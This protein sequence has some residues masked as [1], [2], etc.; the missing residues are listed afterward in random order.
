MVEPERD[1]RHILASELSTALSSPIDAIAPGSL[2]ETDFRGKLPV[3]LAARVPEIRKLLPEDCT[4][5]GLRLN[6]VAASLSGEERP[7]PGALVTIVSASWE[8]RSWARAMLSAVGIELD[9]LCEVDATLSG[10]RERI[11]GEGPVITDVVTG[12]E[13]AALPNL[14][15]FQVIANSSVEQLRTR[16]G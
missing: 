4:C 14:K 13:L 16:I 3:A 1:L 9:C 15:I 6:S 8:I 5:L 7:Q 2:V 12:R 11:R 10:W